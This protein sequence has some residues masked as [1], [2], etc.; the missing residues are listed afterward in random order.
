MIFSMVRRIL[1]IGILSLP[2]LIA[3]SAFA[4]SEFN[5]TPRPEEQKVKFDEIADACRQSKNKDKICDIFIEARQIG[6][7]ALEA[8]KQ[9]IELTKNQY[10]VLTVLNA[11]ATGRVRI[12]SQ[13]YIVNEASLTLDL[14]KDGT[15]LVFDK[16]F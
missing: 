4:H 3:G 6:D 1:F 7:D 10:A 14:Q 8:V 5:L 13:A 2:Q 15:S 12:R 11:L 16:A 9:Y